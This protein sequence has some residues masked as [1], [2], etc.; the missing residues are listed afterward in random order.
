MLTFDNTGKKLCDEIKFSNFELE[1][2]GTK[3]DPEYYTRN[4]NLSREDFEEALDVYVNN[5]D[6]YLEKNDCKR[7]KGLEHW[8][9]HIIE[10]IP[11]DPHDLDGWMEREKYKREGYSYNCPDTVKGK[12]F[13]KISDLVFCMK[14]V[15]RS[16]LLYE[17]KKQKSRLRK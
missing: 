11:S 5:Q 3:M 7:L 8:F 15:D 4:R 6:Y 16:E 12:F 17:T 9:M 13:L 10:P 1:L 2:T 14:D